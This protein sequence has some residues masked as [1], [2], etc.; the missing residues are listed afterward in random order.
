LKEGYA[1][2]AFFG[3]KLADVP[4]PIDINRDGVPDTRAELLAYFDRPRDPTVW[5]ASRIML[6]GP[7]GNPLRGGTAY[8]D[9]YLGK[10]T[11]DWQ[12]SFGIS[13]SFL[14]NFR[15]N[16]LFEFKAG[17]F[18][19]HNLT[20]E[21][22]KAHGTIGRNI[23]QSSEVHA[24]LVNPA[25]TPEQ[26]VDAA[27]RWAKELMG[28]APFD[29]LNA[30]EEADFIRW[31]E[32]SLTYDVPTEFA[33]WFGAR[34]ISLSLAGRNLVLWTK[35]S[36]ADP[37]INSI[38]RGDTYLIGPLDRYYLLGVDAFGVPIPRQYVFTLRLG[39]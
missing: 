2:G 36:G 27:I 26:R 13:G 16:T 18:Y 17:N 21:F 38:G 37:E 34:S 19:V 24:I 29:G 23:R 25:S 5:A 20:D 31:R 9:H 39:L 15:F 8:L 12:G 33:G 6:M 10:P 1:P 30:V 14:K 32:V 28:L 35:Y 7:D 11:P 22:R 3:A 4:I